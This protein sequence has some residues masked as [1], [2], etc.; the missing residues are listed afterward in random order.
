MK[1]SLYDSFFLR[2][3]P[4]FQNCAM[5]MALCRIFST[6]VNPSGPVERS[7]ETSRLNWNVLRSRWRLQAFREDLSIVRKSSAFRGCISTIP[8][9]LRLGI[10]RSVKD[11]SLPIPRLLS[12][13]SSY[14]GATEWCEIRQGKQA[15][16]G[17]IQLC[18]I[19]TNSPCQS[20]GSI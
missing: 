2:I 6:L 17:T 14:I 16:F 10:A 3:L 1:F 9:F 15:D 7:P 12:D 11:V 4:S 19:L 13:L 20:F 5:C 18:L 8:I